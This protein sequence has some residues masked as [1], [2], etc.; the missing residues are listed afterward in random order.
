[1]SRCETNARPAQ[2][3]T[4]QHDARGALW[5]RGLLCL[6]THPRP[7]DSQTAVRAYTKLAPVDG[8]VDGLQQKRTYRG[9]D[10]TC[11]GD[12]ITL[13]QSTECTNQQRNLISQYKKITVRRRPEDHDSNG[14][15]MDN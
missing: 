14:A 1:M 7:S 11:L 12:D 4:Q 2:R 15:T 6:L 13:F 8:Y 3:M 5:W 9:A 10:F